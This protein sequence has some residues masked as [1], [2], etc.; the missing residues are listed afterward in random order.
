[1][2]VLVSSVPGPALSQLNNNIINIHISNNSGNMYKV[3]T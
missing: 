2:Y 1:M 3:I